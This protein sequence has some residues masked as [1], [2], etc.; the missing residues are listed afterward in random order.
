MAFFYKFN[1]IF[2]VFPEDVVG[3]GNKRGNREA[4]SRTGRSKESKG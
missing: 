4:A 3:M 2:V 1:E